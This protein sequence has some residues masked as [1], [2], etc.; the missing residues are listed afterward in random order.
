MTETL[1]A[2]LLIACLLLVPAAK[3][4]APRAITGLIPQAAI[5]AN[6]KAG[7]LVVIDPGHGSRDSAGRITGQGASAHLR[8]TGRSAPLEIPEH[9]LTL[10]YSMWLLR[11]LRA[12][13]IRAVSLRTYDKPWLETPWKGHD[14]ERNNK[15]R[16]EQ[17]DKLGAELIV[18]IHFDGSENKQTSGFTVYYND[19]SI[20]DQA[21]KA[22]GQGKLAGE[23]KHAAR[24]IEARLKAASK[25]TDLGVKRFNRPIYG[26][27]NAKQPAVL[28]ELGYLSN[29]QDVDYLLAKG[30]AEAVTK[31]IAAGVADWLKE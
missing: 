9:E 26:F 31:A 27:I 17:A 18:R 4:P 23:S 21:G 7:P 3:A 25:L 20:Y 10:D 5:P 2:V 12:R 19:Q 22:G 11:A 29:P 8:R 6:P 30:T 15:L 13:G 1:L 16:A 14:V 28:L 24:L